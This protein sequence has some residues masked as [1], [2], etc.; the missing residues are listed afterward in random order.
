MVEHKERKKL[1]FNR[2]PYLSMSRFAKENSRFTSGFVCRSVSG[3]H[4]QPIGR[5]MKFGMGTNIGPN[6]HRIC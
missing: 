3:S 1:L 6:Q 2:F 5:L 4:L